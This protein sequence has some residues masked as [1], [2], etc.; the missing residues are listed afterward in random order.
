MNTVFL[1]IDESGAKGYSDKKE[2]YPGEVGV[3]AGFLIP[4]KYILMVRNELEEIKANYFSDSKIHI[5][6][7]ESEDQ[8]SLRSEIYDY[9]IKR[10]IICVFEAIYSEGFF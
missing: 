3:M 4:E 1:V 2:S 8:E 6:D 7:L 5:T 9:F 10:N